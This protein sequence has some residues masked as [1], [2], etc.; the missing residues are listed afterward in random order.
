MAKRLLVGIVILINVLMLRS[1][2]AQLSVEKHIIDGGL[3]GVYWIYVRGDDIAAAGTGGN[4]RWYGNNGSGNFGGQTIGNLSGAWSIHA[5]D[6]DGDGDLDFVASSPT[7]DEV[8]WYERTGGGYT[9][10]LIDDQGQDPESVYAAD[11]DD[12]GDIDIAVAVW[13]SQQIVWFENRGGRNFVKHVL[14]SNMP[15]AHSV[16]AAD[17]DRDGDMDL[18]G[19]GS[20]QTSWWRNNGGGSFSKSSLASNG[21]W[22]VFA[23]DIDSDGDPDVLRTQRNN[24]DVDWLQNGGFAEHTVASG[25]GEC[26]AV[27][28]GDIDGDG[29][30]DIAAAG[31]DNG[32]I[33]VW[34]NDGSENFTEV[35]IDSRLGRSRGIG[36]GDFDG[37]GD[38]DVAAGLSNM[39]DVVWYEVVG[40]GGGN[41]AAI[42]VTAP[43]GGETLSAGSPFNI[44]WNSNGSISN[45]EIEFS[46][47]GGNSWN[48]ITSSTTN[49]G[50]HNWTVPDSP[51]SDCRVRISDASDGNPSDVSNG[52]FTITGSPTS[53][54][55]TRP[56]GGESWTAGTS[57][58]I[59]WTS[60]GVIA[61]VRLEYS[62]NNGGSWSNIVAST[63]NDG[64]FNWNIPAVE[65]D[66]ALVRVSDA[67][68]SSINDISDN[69][70]TIESGASASVALTVPNGGEIWTAGTS[71]QVN[72]TSTGVI[73]NVRLE[74]SLNNGSSWSNI[75]ASTNN[76]GSFNWNIPAVESDEALVRVS[77]AG[78]GSINDVSDNV[79]TIESGAS[80]SMALT[81]PNGGEIWTGGTSQTI[82]WTSA[83][84]IPNVRLEYSLNNGGSWSNIIASTNND[85]SFNWNIPAVESDEA[86]VRV[87]DAGNGSI[88]DVSD[89]VFNIISGGGGP[90]SLTLVSPN[91]N[92]KLTIGSTHAITWTSTGAVV[93]VK[94]EYSVNNGGAWTTI[95]NS[96]S[97][98]GSFSWNV[99]AATS[100]IALMRISDASN[101]D[102]NDVSDATFSLLPLVDSPIAVTSPNGGE[103][104]VVGSQHDVSWTAPANI[105]NVRLQYSLNSGE[106][107]TTF[108]ASTP[109]DGVYGW[110]LPETESDNTLIRVSDASNVNVFDISNGVFSIVAEGAPTA[111]LTLTSPNGGEDW[112]AGTTRQ[113]TWSSTGSIA[114]VKLEYSTNGGGSWTIIDNSTGNDGLFDWNVPA[115]ESNN[116]VVRVSDAA[117][118]ATFDVSNAVFAIV[119]TPTLTLVSP[120]G[121]ESWTAGSQEEIRWTSTGS[122]AS[123][124][125]EYSL[126]NGESWTNID[127][128]INNDGGFNWNIPDVESENAL[129]RISD[130]ANNDISDTSDSPFSITR[131]SSLTLTTPNGGEI[132]QAGAEQQ[133][134][135][136]AVEASDLVK[137]EYSINN[138][139][140]WE[141]I[142]ASTANDGSE[143]W[144]VPLIES[145]SALVRISDASDPAVFDVSDSLFKIVAEPSMTVTAPNGGEVWYNGHRE[146]ITWNFTGDFLEAR[147]EYSRD[148]GA[149]WI[150][151]RNDTENDGRFHW[152]P[153]SIESD[154]MLVR[155]SDTFDRDVFDVSDSM[156]SIRSKSLALTVPN[157]GETW[158]SGSTHAIE[159]VSDG[160]IDSLALEFS[161]NN[162]REW[163]KIAEVRNPRN[164]KSYDWTIPTIRSDSVLVRIT[165]LSDSTLADTNDAIFTITDGVLAITSPNGG[166]SWMSGSEQ[167]I[168]WNSAGEMDS[169]KIE[170]SL[171]NGGVWVPV[172]AATSNTGSYVWTLP[173]AESNEA[174]IYISNAAD[175]SPSDVSDGVFTIA[176]EVINVISPNGG[177]VWE[178]GET[179]EIK[180]NSSESV[181]EVNLEYAVGDQD[182]VVIADSMPN[183]GSYMWQTP[184]INSN[185]VAVRISDADDGKPADVS[186]EAFSITIV[187]GIVESDPSLPVDFELAQNYPNPFNIETKISFATPK[188]NVVRLTIYNT[189]GELVRTVHAGQLAPGKYTAQWDG[190][191]DA[192][193]IVATGAYIYRIEIGEW[194]AVRR[195][196][197]IK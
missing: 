6:I 45:V 83:G 120:N 28:G 179:Y 10:H 87:S 113:I 99:P 183:G 95:S 38:E 85:G 41:P 128:G 44:Q 117:N 2:Q 134:T 164:N 140:V 187:S 74:Y 76:D 15:G 147:I 33:V 17:L 58:Q 189:L 135:W 149:N 32:N 47:N 43:N 192:G 191:N 129:V 150:V 3:N 114:A 194:Q 57:Q 146:T 31:F 29:D 98:D 107:W 34:L 22:A 177:E 159:W 84:S 131:A 160:P 127:N 158:L 103:I 36:V 167:T 193:V 141:M 93:N 71:Q 23:V 50:S 144:T 18:L 30:T 14:E 12:D 106:S 116:A 62:L 65:S 166:E 25:F 169:V 154:S 109:N 90:A 136:D 46:T 89:N 111:T 197:L 165:D 66:E 185:S 118:A 100:V 182:W 125:L 64:S 54:T 173:E 170:Y 143:D 137:L 105:A 82:N 162:G 73:A 186:D 21:S 67:G 53:V 37:D 108:K 132:W 184:A 178:S 69:V 145:D 56:N 180:W 81:V 122:I 156:F 63:N 68:N 60:T 78:N 91:G 171:D 20:N 110:A 195:M 77:D 174:L 151:L 39:D 79:F 101:S 123:V 168:A 16:H 176:G 126:D 104:W 124:K 7:T 139:E 86:L 88:N 175:N 181:T 130:A 97:N 121:G 94:L 190:R 80:A 1:A 115:V 26:W 161:A 138:G 4:L 24:G 59:N 92:E 48:T 196:S 157:G 152:I 70:F 5:E 119:I 112:D 55:M 51:S 61:N 163:E 72:W 11:Y 142:F 49:D 75:I 13:E 155:V 42:T 52:S 40:T 153:E 96:T 19:S 8:V 35:E 188:T 102:I 27:S 148:N 9:R 172:I 133:I